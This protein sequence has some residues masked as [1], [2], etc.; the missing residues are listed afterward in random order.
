VTVRHGRFAV[1]ATLVLALLTGCGTIGGNGDSSSGNGAVTLRLTWWGNPTRAAA[2]QAAVAL[3]EQSHP[4]I[5]VQAEPS[6]YPGYYDKLNTQI[7]AGDAPDVFQADVV[8]RYAGTGSVANLSTYR[9]TLN[10]S[11]FDAGYLAQGSYH[12]SLYEIPAGANVFALVYDPSAISKAGARAPGPGLTWQQYAQL[13]EAITASSGGK[14]WGAGDDSAS[15]QAL[16]FF[17]RQRGHNLYAT[18]GRSLGF[19]AQD[20]IDWWQYW[21]DLRKSGGVPPQDVT[22]PGVTGDVTKVPIAKGQVAMDVWGTST[23]L[24]G[25]NWQ[26][27]AI[28]GEAGHPGMYLKRSV[29]WAVYG[30]SKHPKEAAELIDFLVNDQRAGLKLGMTRGAPA[31]SAVLGALTPT[32]SGADKQV[33][34]YTQYVAEPGHNSPPPPQ[35]PTAA[36]Q[37]E[38][39]LFVRMAE[40]VWYGRNSVTDAA[41]QFV[42]QAN[43]LLASGS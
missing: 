43:Q 11:K 34:T 14:M 7:S 36:L 19:T 10:T 27:T 16:E 6:A 35:F 39:D 13:A 1:A 32:L 21:A 18:D 23:T 15:T 29:N 37:I 2:T 33:A 31:N 30:N 8:A 40:N 28:P 26:Y 42:S 12:G 9:N 4:G 20:L 41:N 38:T 17:V 5:T 25:T 3:F 24:P 22:E